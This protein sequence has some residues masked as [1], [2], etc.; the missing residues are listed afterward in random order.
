[1]SVSSKSFNYLVQFSNVSVKLNGITILEKINLNMPHASWIAIIGPNGAGK[2]TLLLAL[3][4]QVAYSGKISFALQDGSERSLRIGYVPQKYSVDR[5]LPITV[6]EFLMMSYQKMPLWFGSLKRSGAKATSLLKLVGIEQIAT[7]RVA[8]LSGGELQRLLLALALQ[9]E[10]EL[11]I[12]D[13]P[14]AGIDIQGE[15]IFCELLENLRGKLNFTIL[16]VSH[17]LGMIMHHS[18]Y[19]VLLN[20]TVIAEGAPE[21]VITQKNLLSLFGLHMGIADTKLIK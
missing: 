18:S 15:R 12:L 11:L 19:A 6:I 1:M 16:M 5:T 21:E 9:Y 13:E 10:P 3:L 7:R 20:K 17:D 8:E 14:T 2:T 4:K